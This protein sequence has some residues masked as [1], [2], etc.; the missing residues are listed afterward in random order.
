MSDTNQASTLLVFRQ[1]NSQNAN[2]DS[3]QSKDKQ[4]LIKEFSY[5]QPLCSQWQ[6]WYR[7]AIMKNVED[8]TSCFSH[9]VYGEK[10]IRA[11]TV[12]RWFL[13]TPQLRYYYKAF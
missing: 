6:V 11:A 3:L 8:F 9:P 13:S 5:L 10:K 2:N 7:I 1:D 12:K 4:D